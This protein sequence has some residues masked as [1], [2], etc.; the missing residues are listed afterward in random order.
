MRLVS[1]VKGKSLFVKI[2]GISS[3]FV[4]LA[5]LIMAAL[6]I[7]A[8]RELSLTTAVD[9]GEKKLRSDMASAEYIFDNEVGVLRLHNNNLVDQEGNSLYRQYDLVDRMSKDLGVVVTNFV[10]DGSDYGKQG[11]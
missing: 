4:F 8:M 10:R 9:M 11:D 5:I 2:S 6:G 7:Y 1:K 3:I